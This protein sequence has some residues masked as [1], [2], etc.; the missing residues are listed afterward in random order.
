MK[1]DS[2][3]VAIVTGVTRGIGRAILDALVQRGVR[4]VACARDEKRIAELATRMNYLG[5]DAVFVEGDVREA[6][7]ASTLVTQA[8]EN[9]G[10]LDLV[11]NNAGLINSPGNIEDLSTEQWRDVL[12][13]NLMGAVFLCRAAVPAL[14]N[15]GGGVIVNMSSYWGHVGS[16]A[17]GPYCASKFAVEAVSQCLAA[18]TKKDKIIV[19]AVRPGMVVTDML[20]VATRGHAHGH[21]PPEKC[22]QQLLDLVENLTIEDTGGPRDLG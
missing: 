3:K 5:K 11:I 12:D 6:Q 21:K 22:A 16:P 17:F 8:E 7:T 1:L 19:A 20:E 15:R 13:V 14:R 18:E 10:G 9:F 2:S 4:I